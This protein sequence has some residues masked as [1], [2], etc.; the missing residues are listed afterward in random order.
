M[1]TNVIESPHKFM[2]TTLKL[3]GPKGLHL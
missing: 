1:L 2:H 3:C